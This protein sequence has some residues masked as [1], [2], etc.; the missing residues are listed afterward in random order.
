M[1]ENIMRA[2][3]FDREVDRVKEGKCPA[4]GKIVDLSRFKDNLSRQEFTISGLCQ[5]CQDDI[6]SSGDE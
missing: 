2:A 3:G 4:C 6:F 5:D 1:N